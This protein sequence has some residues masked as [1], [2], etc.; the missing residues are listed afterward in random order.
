[1]GNLAGYYIAF[2]AFIVPTVEETVETV[3]KYNPDTGAPYEVEQTTKHYKWP[4]WTR[5][6]FAYS[7]YDREDFED[8][9]HLLGNVTP[10]NEPPGPLIW[11]E[12]E[13]GWKRAF[14]GAFLEHRLGSGWELSESM[15]IPEL[16]PDESGE[17]IQFLARHGVPV[18]SVGYY[19]V[20]AS[21]G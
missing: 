6:L 17:I 5:P 3:T 13:A 12:K 19:I 11:V 2:G 8:S 14:V 7:D 18:E 9:L 1:M 20:D 15:R 10:T 16:S 21:E 4:E